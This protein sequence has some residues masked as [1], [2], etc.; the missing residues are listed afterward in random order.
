MTKRQTVARP[1]KQRLRTEEAT[2]SSTVHSERI[3]RPRQSHRCAKYAPILQ[4]L[5][6]PHVEFELS[7]SLEPA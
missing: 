1:L 6:E 7:Y 4:R 5:Q 2:P 3:C